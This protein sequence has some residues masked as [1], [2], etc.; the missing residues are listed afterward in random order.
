MKLIEE[1]KHYQKLSS[2][3]EYEPLPLTWEEFQQK[4]SNYLNHPLWDMC[5]TIEYYQWT[6]HEE[7]KED[8]RRY[9]KKYQTKFTQKDEEHS[10][11]TISNNVQQIDL[12]NTSQE[13]E[14][15]A[16]QPCHPIDVI[17]YSHNYA[18]R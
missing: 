9:Y 1:L 17:F 12:Q 13:Q 4:T 5:S 10:N 6:T 11:K 3:E 14:K 16:S 18:P 15:S 8:S 7:R 2:E